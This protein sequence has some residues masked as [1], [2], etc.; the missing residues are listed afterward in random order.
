M[1]CYRD[2]NFLPSCDLRATRDRSGENSPFYR[3][4]VSARQ[5]RQDSREAGA[6]MVE[7]QPWR[8]GRLSDFDA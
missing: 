8:G 4:R 2:P 7:S 5:S 6:A 1:I 3:L